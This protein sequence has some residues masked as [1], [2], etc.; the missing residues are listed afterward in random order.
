MCLK[1]AVWLFFVL[2]RSV[3]SYARNPLFQNFTLSNWWNPKAKY[4]KE[5]LGPRRK[6]EKAKESKKE[7]A[8]KWLCDTLT[9]TLKSHSDKKKVDKS[10]EQKGMS[11]RDA[12]F[13][14]TNMDACQVDIMQVPGTSI[15]S[16][17]Q[18]ALASTDTLGLLF[19]PSAY[20]ATYSAAYI[21]TA[22]QSHQH[23]L[24]P[25]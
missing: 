6:N 5:Y 11:A 2:T 22:I 20:S 12:S 17:G 25:A 3:D 7:K 16:T 8:I 9:G 4:G 1:I 18:T 24:Y 10:T 14:Q 19:S 21:M 13:V 23:Q 15:M